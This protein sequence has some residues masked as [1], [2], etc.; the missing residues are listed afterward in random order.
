MSSI[1]VTGNWTSSG[2]L[3]LGRVVGESGSSAPAPAARPGRSGRTPAPGPAESV[4]RMAPYEASRSARRMTTV[5]S[6]S[7]GPPR[8]SCPA[9][10][11]LACSAH[12]ASAAL[13]LD[14]LLLDH[15]ATAGVEHDHQAVDRQ[16]A[17]RQRRRRHRQPD[18][19]RR[20]LQLRP[21]VDQHHEER[22]ELEHHVQQRRQV[23]FERGLAPYAVL[24]APCW[25]R[26]SEWQPRASDEWV[27]CPVRV[28]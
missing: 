5:G 7:A 12:H 25:L 14:G 16:V 24:A 2:G 10:R 20:P 4:R 17:P 3:Q 9:R 8:V 1:G 15:Q 27:E 21:E 18:R 28:D 26:E 11:R 19:L 22:D 6:S 13:P 23:E